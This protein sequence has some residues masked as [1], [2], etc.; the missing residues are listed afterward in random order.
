MNS[1]FVLVLVLI[2]RA[3]MLI[4]MTMIT[5]ILRSMMMISVTM[6]SVTMISMTMISMTMIIGLE[7]ILAPFCVGLSGH[8]YE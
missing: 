3:M 2:S 5:I 7:L 8:S 6:V 1:G 4:S